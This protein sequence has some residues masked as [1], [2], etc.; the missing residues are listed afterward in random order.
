MERQNPQEIHQDP[1]GLDKLTLPLKFESTLSNPILP[2]LHPQGKLCLFFVGLQTM[3]FLYN[4]WSVPLRFSF[5]VYQNEGNAVLWA[6][7]D[8][9]AD[10]VYLLDTLVVK[11]RVMFLD[12]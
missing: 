7:A 8:A 10:A 3:A 2:A 4:A 6:A 1:P 9:M 5:H 12:G 11:P